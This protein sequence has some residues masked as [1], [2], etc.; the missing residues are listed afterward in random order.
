MRMKNCKLLLLSIKRKSFIQKLY[1]HGKLFFRK[2]LSDQNCSDSN[3]SPGNWK[4]CNGHDTTTI[5]SLYSIRPLHG[6][7]MATTRPLHGHDTAT[8]R[9]KCIST[10]QLST[11]YRWANKNTSNLVIS[12]L[13]TNYK[14]TSGHFVAT[15]R[16]LA[17]K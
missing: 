8:I 17:G 13:L 6:H 3:W 15:N 7:H 5:R 2:L 14:P 11:G 4:N 10:I 9:P 16:P 1:S 12:R